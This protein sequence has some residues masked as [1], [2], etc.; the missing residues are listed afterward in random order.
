MRAAP[1]GRTAL[2]YGTGESDRSDLRVSRN[3]RLAVAGGPTDLR[4]RSSRAGA[5]RRGAHLD[6]TPLLEAGLDVLDWIIA[7]QTDPTGPLADRQR[8]VATRRGKVK[9]DQQ[10]I[11]ATA[12]LLAAESAYEAT[13]DDKYHAAMERAYAWFLG[14]NDLHVPVGRPAARRMLRRSHAEGVNEN[15]GAESTLMWL[16][17]LERDRGH[18][19]HPAKRP[20]GPE[21]CSRC[22]AMTPPHELFERSAANPILTVADVPYPANSVFNPGA[23]RAGRDGPPG[24]GRGSAWDLPAARR[25]QPRRAAGLA[26]RRRA[27]LRSDVAQAPEEIWGCE[28]PGSHGFPSARSGRSPTRPTA[29]V[30]HSSHWP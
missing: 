28:D 2:A 5:Y 12:L 10:P 8:M 18:P 16:I 11:E 19:R 14:E 23:A 17:A 22:R 30:G 7:L 20:R 29:V 15:Q 27:L 3:V 25:P 26:V 4:E 13:G 24:P 6:S 1:T 9:F 21:P